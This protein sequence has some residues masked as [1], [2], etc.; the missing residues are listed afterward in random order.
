MIAEHIYLVL[1]LADFSQLETMQDCL[2]SLPLIRHP[3]SEA[4]WVSQT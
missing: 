3:C 4:P 2:I 1:V